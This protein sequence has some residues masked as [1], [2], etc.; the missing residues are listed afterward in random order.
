MSQSTPAS[1][2]SWHLPL[3]F[4]LPVLLLLVLLAFWPGLKGDFLF[5][6][7]PN[8]I[9]NPLV[10][11]QSLD[12]AALQHAIAGYQ[13]GEIGRPLATLS[14]A[15]NWYLGGENPL[16]YKLVN[17]GIHLLNAALVFFLARRLLSLPTVA[18]TPW[19]KWAPFAI[20]LFWAAHPLQVSTVLYIVQRMETLALSFV[21]LGLL[22]Y[23]HGRMKQTEGQRGWPWLLASAI[24][25][26]LGLSS[27]ETAALFPVYAFGLELTVL[28]FSAR[29][30]HT[31]RNWKWAYT[32]AMAGGAL[33]FC[34]KILPAYLN[35]AIYEFRGFTLAERLLT[36][37]R[38]LVMY[39]GQILLPLPSHLTFY[40]DD[41]RVSHGWMDPASTLFCTLLLAT[42]LGL[43]VWLRKRMP[44]F[45]LGVL[46]FFAAHLLTSNVIP[47]ELVFEHRNYFALFGIGLAL[48]DLIH[49]LPVSDLRLK[50][51]LA[52]I[53]LTGLFAL[54][55]IRA[56][57]WGDPFT[58]ALTLTQINP[59][60]ARASNDLAVL[61]A[62][63]IK[64]NPNSPYFN[65]AEAEFE[66]GAKLPSASPLPEQG[67]ILLHAT[68]GL[69]VDDAWWQNLIGKLQNR[70]L[71]PQD[72]MAATGLLQQ[73]YKGVPLDDSR[74]SQALQ[75]L[76]K[77]GYGTPS[78]YASTG[79][80]ALV[81]LHDD[82]LA[83]RM[84]VTA[85]EKSGNDPE[86]ARRI[87]TTLLADGHA[88]QAALVGAKLSQL[89]LLAPPPKAPVSL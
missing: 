17:L 58:L 89:G 7:F 1:Q 79:D 50:P 57:T 29:A 53:S 73:R 8:I 66:R 61:Y 64:D 35:P 71:G 25:A 68:L 30:P 32:L 87:Y 18:R 51:L 26:M 78:L 36:Q 54:T 21:L 74:L 67:L 27:K 59:E 10:H 42:L 38:V 43:A 34:L 63:M 70:P 33:V 62:G 60:S 13:P 3:A 28:G 40:Y 83:N 69:P 76:L 56:A 81:Y 6:D 82:E 85:V 37:S 16:G 9:T 39:L 14:L 48:A 88:R 44:L 72:I 65:M 80:H 47:L 4:A 86:F 11:M 84:F 23:L 77:R 75:I 45:A 2:P 52:G 19:S 5:D 22:A 15:L 49:H 55:G 20:A 12:A 41:F 46:W 31:N 24:V